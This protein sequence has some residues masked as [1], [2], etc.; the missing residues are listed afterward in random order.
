MYRT[1]GF[2]VGFAFSLL[3]LGLYLL[4]L[5]FRN[6]NCDANFNLNRKGSE[7]IGKALNIIVLSVFCW[8][9]RIFCLFCPPPSSLSFQNVFALLSHTML[10]LLFRMFVFVALGRQKNADCNSATISGHHYNDNG[11]SDWTV[12]NVYYFHE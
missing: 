4:F 11:A 5:I 7:L 3:I 8:V 6:V 10:L 2:W 12:L 1:T 9:K